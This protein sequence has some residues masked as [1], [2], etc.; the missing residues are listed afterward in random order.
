MEN[1]SEVPVVPA[2]NTRGY[3]PQVP[4]A[5]AGVCFGQK[6]QGVPAPATGTRVHLAILIWK[7]KQKKILQM[8][9]VNRPGY[10]SKLNWHHNIPTLT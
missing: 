1:H 4:G 8:L 10:L 2:Q 7:A 9:F 5:G 3:P 6:K